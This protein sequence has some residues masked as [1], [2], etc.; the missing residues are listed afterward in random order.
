MNAAQLNEI[1]VN[2]GMVQISTYCTSTLYKKRNAGMFFDGVDG[3][4][5][6][7]RGKRSECLTFMEGKQFLVS[8]RTYTRKAA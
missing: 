4:I 6:V 7:K 1:L 5:Y 8:V 3:N 2:D